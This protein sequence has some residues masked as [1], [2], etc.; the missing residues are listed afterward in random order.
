[1]QY[2]ECFVENIGDDCIKVSR[3][4]F[5]EE[6]VSFMMYTGNNKARRDYILSEWGLSIDANGELVTSG[7]DSVRIIYFD[8]KVNPNGFTL[9]H[10]RR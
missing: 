4:F 9:I 2:G 6:G 7:N 1:L 5:G 10:S 8:N 3:I